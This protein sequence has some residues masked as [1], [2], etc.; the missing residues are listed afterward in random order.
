[1]KDRKLYCKNAWQHKRKQILVRDNYTCRECR[2]YGKYKN[3]N[4]VHHIYPAEF[5]PE[6]AFESWNLITLCQ[7]CHNEMHDRDSHDV[8]AKGKEW[9]RR[10]DKWRESIGRA[11]GLSNRDGSTA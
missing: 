2:R 5:Y 6:W 7:A 1:M 11:D 9:Q 3:A 4:H 8:T 10:A